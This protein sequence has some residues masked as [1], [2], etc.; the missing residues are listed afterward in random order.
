MLVCGQKIAF[1]GDP[2]GKLK[3][4]CRR[5]SQ[6]VVS[7]QVVTD[8]CCG[9]SVIFCS[10]ISHLIGHETI[11][12]PEIFSGVHGFTGKTVKILER[13]VEGQHFYQATQNGTRTANAFACRSNTHILKS[14]GYDLTIQQLTKG[15]LEK[16][17]KKLHQ[18]R[19]VESLEES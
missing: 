19:N 16:V 12:I 4:S 10:F 1:S 2:K 17:C 11:N 14:S 5:K 18:I 6:L 8:P 15:T 7:Y 9:L 13:L 3:I